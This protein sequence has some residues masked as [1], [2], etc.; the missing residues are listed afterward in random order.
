[1]SVVTESEFLIGGD[2]LHR[3][4]RCFVVTTERA[5]IEYLLLTRGHRLS[6]RAS[7]TLMIWSAE[8]RP[9]RRTTR[10][11]RSA[12]GRS[13]RAADRTLARKSRALAT[14]V[15]RE[16]QPENLMIFESPCSRG[17]ASNETQDQRPRP[18]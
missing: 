14:A 10:T 18:R 6:E 17:S 9:I 8:E 11:H 1:M 5:R 12:R 7:P 2:S 16:R 15:S 3:L 13:N 4:V